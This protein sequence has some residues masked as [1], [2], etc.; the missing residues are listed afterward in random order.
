[1]TFVARELH[2]LGFKIVA[3]H[4]TA[5]VLTRAGIPTELV[6]SIG[7]GRPTIHDYI[8]NNAVHL[9]INTPSGGA[10]APNE[11]K[12]RMLALEHNITLITTLAGAQAG[13]H[14]IQAMRD[15]DLAVKP[16]QDYYAD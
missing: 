7:K 4:G 8:M 10:H 14:G 5:K 3:T 9:I 1:V 15:F 13:A 16:I 12:I 11:D 2:E 6:Y